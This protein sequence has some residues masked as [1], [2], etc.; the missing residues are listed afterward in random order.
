MLKH[1]GDVILIVLVFL[2]AVWFLP[3]VPERH[4]YTAYPPG[5]SRNQTTYDFVT[6][7]DFFGQVFLGK[8]PRI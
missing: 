2:L 4:M 5:D 6:G 1:I 7:S 8:T 3:I